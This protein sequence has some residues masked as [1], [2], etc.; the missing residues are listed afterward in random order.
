MLAS[1]ASRQWRNVSRADIWNLLFVILPIM[2]YKSVAPQILDSIKKSNHILLISHEK[3][4]GDTLGASLAM[5]HFFDRENKKYKHFCPD[6]P[7]AYFNFLP[8]I[9]KIIF[10]YKLIE[11][12]EHD[13]ILIIDCGDLKRT[14]IEN[15][16]ILIKEEKNII[17]IDHHQSN[18][19]FGRLNLVV[20]Q[21]SS[22]SEI[23]YNFFTFNA[24]DIDKYMATSL[25]TGILTD[26]MNFTNAATNHESLK[27]ASHLLAKGARVNQI[28]SQISQNKNLKALKLWGNIL[29]RLEFNPQYNAAYTVITKE[30]LKDKQVSL[31]DA[32]DGLANFLS[33]LQDIDFILVLSEE[34]DNIIKGS[35]RTTKENI[36]VSQIAKLLGGGGHKKA[37]GFKIAGK[38]AKDEKG[39]YIE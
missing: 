16:L 19:N 7:P 28:I 3:P 31:E 29:S 15:D 35:L 32:R 2:P 23:I 37:A 6:K 10:N 11:L 26:T 24:I 8:K 14:K 39:W 4:D 1:Q 21:A 9:E 27:I 25:L 20:P 36:D 17:N 30:D 12:K 5:A 38:L 13:L 33:N 18:N 34:D 22:T